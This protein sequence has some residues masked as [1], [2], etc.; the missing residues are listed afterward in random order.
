MDFGY[1]LGDLVV[2]IA[3]LLAGGLVMGVA[4]GLLGI[5]GGGILVPVFYEVFGIMGVDDAVRMHLCVATSMAVI[6]PTSISSIR[7]HR[8]KGAIDASVVRSLALPVIVGVCAGVLVAKFVKGDALKIIWVIAA[9]VMSL[10]LMFGRESWVLGDAI[11]GQP[12]RTLFGLVV[13][14]V[15]TLMSIAG[16]VFI[17]NLMTL[18]GRPM[19]QAVGTASA[20]GPIVSIPAT[21]GFIWAGWNAANLPPGSVGYVSLLGAAIVIPTSV[22]AAP[23]GA[24]LAHRVSRRTLELAFA[25]FLATVG[26]RFVI[27]LL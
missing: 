24:R 23:Y 8:A 26:I 22:A 15:S 9:S 6:I 2:P 18:Y 5:G 14:T 1:P 16:G 3:A 4:A 7:T 11:P 19:Q 25:I 20:F 21:L 27:S 17:S 13:G 12:F 10:K